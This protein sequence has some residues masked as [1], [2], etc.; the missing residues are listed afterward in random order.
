[1]LNVTPKFIKGLAVGLSA[2]LIQACGIIDD[3]DN[4][5]NSGPIGTAKVQVIHA[6]PDAPAVN[7][8]AGGSTLLE[9]FDYG[10]ASPRLE[11]DAGDLEVEVQGLL[12]DGSTPSVIGPVSLSLMADF[13]Y[14]VLAVDNVSNIEALVVNRQ[15]NPIETGQLRAQ[16]VHAAPNAPL[17][18][19]YVTA[20]SAILAESA[21]LGT[22]DFKGGVGPV[23]VPAGDY[24]I[25]VT[26]AGDPAQVVFD[27]GTVALSA[28]LDLTIAA[29]ENTLTGDAPINL[30]VATNEGSFIIQDS[31]AT[32]D[33]RVVHASPN[34]PN[35]DVYVNDGAD[36][37]ISNLAYPEFT[38]FIPLP[39]DTYNFKVTATGADIGTAV[40]DADVPLAQGQFY[41][42]LAVDELATIE[43]LLLN[44]DRRRVATAAKVQIVHASPS[45]GIVDIY[46]TAPGTDISTVE[47]AISGFEFKN[48]TDGFIQLPEG[49]YDI[50][51]TP[52]GTTDAAIDLNDI[53]LDAG[54]LYTVIAR[55]AA[56]PNPGDSPLP[57]NVILL[58]DF[59]V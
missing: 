7:V 54:G 15:T 28:G 36:P 31:A 47:P 56:R 42:V 10:S 30:L 18:D 21:A 11:V 1:M 13:E 29:I 52:T 37:A 4:N 22:I 5:S 23:D 58:D 16:V 12:P 57:L 6:S 34:A 25:R 53:Q 17:V 35:V 3:D 20:P 40:I 39:A 19:V 8:L 49:T 14:T 9:G 44:A 43:P 38:S 27:S 41:S 32:A 46:V 51:V 50:T 26:I 24:R 59:N 45:A 48:T 33:V 55:D 2:A